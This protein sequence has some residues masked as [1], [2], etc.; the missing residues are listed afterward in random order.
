MQK[1]F[2]YIKGDKVIWIVAIILSAFSIL[3]VY[4]ATSTLVFKQKVWNTE[5]YLL[6]HFGLLVIGFFLMY[7]VHLVQFRYFAR[8][9]QILY[10]ISIPLLAYTLF[11]GEEI[12]EAKRWILIPGLNLTFQSSD[13]AKI[14]LILF[15]A[16]IMGGREV[17]INNWKSVVMLLF[18]PIFII[19]GLIAPAGNSTAGLLLLICFLML[20]YGGV[21]GKILSRFVGYSVV[22][23][24]VL[25]GFL[26]LV[27]PDSTRINT[28]NTRIQ[29]FLFEDVQPGSHEEQAMIA[30]AN[31]RLFGK[32]PGHSTQKYRLPHPYSDSLYPFFIEEYGLLGGIV[33]LLMFLILLFRGI[34]I[35]IRAPGKFSG[36]AAL[37]ITL[38]LVFQA[39]MHIMVAVRLFPTTG[40]PL[41]FL[42]M[43]GTSIL[44][45]FFAMGILL[46][47]SREVYS[48]DE[49]NT[50]VRKTA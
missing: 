34:R 10:V 30:I 45:A 18:L 43:G 6:K 31:G 14:A 9:A 35:A 23:L 26:A 50:N 20:Y 48:K 3:A 27:K 16:R 17:D 11:F 41:P 28:L 5:F 13:L 21:S 32:M 12:N 7:L 24:I 47:I 19:I 1:F 33:I 39:F 36:L 8:I 42:S 29:Y 49:E 44:F 15:V 4:S 2:S 38:M 22:G 37:G 40:Q 46:S 25:F